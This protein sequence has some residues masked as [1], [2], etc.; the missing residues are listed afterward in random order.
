[1]T[2]ELGLKAN[3]LK[4]LNFTGKLYLQDSLCIQNQKLFYLSRKLAKTDKVFSTW[5]FNNVINIQLKKD[6]RSYKIYHVSDLEKLLGI[7][8]VFTYLKDMNLI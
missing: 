2:R 5:F 3:E 4:E 8:D 1:M 6:G 7:A